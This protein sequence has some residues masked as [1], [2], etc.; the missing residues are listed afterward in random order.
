MLIFK[1]LNEA[2]VYFRVDHAVDEHLDAFLDRRPG[3][4]QF[5]GVNGNAD[6]MDMALLNCRANDRPEAIDRMIFVDNVPDLDQVRFVRGEFTD[7]FARLIRC[8]DFYNW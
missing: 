5:G 2:V 8:I 3:S 4:F 7:K 1:K 6:M